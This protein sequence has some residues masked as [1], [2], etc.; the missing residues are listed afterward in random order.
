MIPLQ[1]LR[2]G[3]YEGV[4]FTYNDTAYTLLFDP[5]KVPSG[6]IKAVRKN[7]VLYDRPFTEEVQ[8][9]KA[10]DFLK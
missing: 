1:L 4:S 5:E 7:R 10:V 3:K 8:P 9:Q 2:Q 6:H